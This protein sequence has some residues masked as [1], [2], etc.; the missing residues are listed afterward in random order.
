LP[1][2]WSRTLE[3]Y[4]AANGREAVQLVKELRP[5]LILMDVGMPAVMQNRV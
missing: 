5:D 3:I 4:E 2:T 1:S